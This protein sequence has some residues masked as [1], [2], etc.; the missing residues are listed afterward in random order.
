MFAGNEAAQSAGGALLEEGGGAALSVAVD[1]VTTFEGNAATCCYAGGHLTGVG[2]SCQDA[3]TGYQSSWCVTLHLPLRQ[4]LLI[5]LEVSGGR[6]QGWRALPL[7]E[8]EW[9]QRH[10]GRATGPHKV[11]Q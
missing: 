7:M 3:S 2:G 8:F 4:F 11:R 10:K 6:H 5:C 1:A 9:G